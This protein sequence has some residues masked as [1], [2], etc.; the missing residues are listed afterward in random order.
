LRVI[1]YDH[2]RQ[3]RKVM[4]S[5]AEGVRRFNHETE[6][7]NEE[8]YTGPTA[9]DV[10]VTI[11]WG[12]NIQKI[13][14]DQHARGK[15]TI[16]IDDAYLMRRGKNR[17]YGI[18]RNERYAFG[19]YP[20]VESAP[21]DRWASLGL[22][23]APWR[24]DGTHVLIADQGI[25]KLLADR[26]WA[27]DEDGHFPHLS[28]GWERHVLSVLHKI[29]K[30]TV[31][32]RTHPLHRDARE[33]FEK[34]R[35]IWLESGG[36]DEQLTFSPGNLSPLIDDLKGAWALITYGSNSCIESVI[37]GIPVFTGSRTMADAV[38]NKNLFDLESP[39]MPDRAHWSDWIASAQ[40]TEA[41]MRQ[42][43]P[44][45]WLVEDYWK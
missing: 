38:G 22:E 18:A 10:V 45:K 36:P 34:C 19:D 16:A 41:E 20:P 40:W 12:D 14:D 4:E 11:E 32:F 23:L 43:L 8:D 24:A 25:R 21:P 15:P 44:W 29:T 1:L 26:S 13:H 42:G 7:A 35:R 37:A 27:Y 30:R 3:W 39:A 9:R 17:Y 2:K 33:W 5:L 31:R 6:I 28:K